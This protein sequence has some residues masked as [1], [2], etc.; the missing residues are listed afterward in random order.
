MKLTRLNSYQLVLKYLNGFGPEGQEEEVEQP[1]SLED[2]FSKLSEDTDL[3]SAPDEDLDEG[4]DPET[5]GD[6]G[7]EQNVDDGKSGNQDD[8]AKP[9]V[10]DAPAEQPAETKPAVE[11][12]T[13]TPA[14]ETPPAQPEPLTAEQEAEQLKQLRGALE[15]S[16]AL[17]DEDADA[18]LTDPKTALPR[19]MANAHLQIMG[20]V[21]QMLQHVVPQILEVTT[22]QSQTKQSIN[23]KFAAR[24]P[25]LAADAANK[26][27]VIAAIQTVKAANPTLSVDEVI[28]KVG[29]VAY[30]IIG[31]PVPVAAPAAQQQ[32]APKVTPP[33]ARPHTPA[34]S[35]VTPPK[36]T[37]TGNHLVDFISSLVDNKE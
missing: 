21:A 18:V 20:Q 16:Y 22:K 9:A 23:D 7:G 33:K 12:P 10:T 25:E 8:P 1:S 14:V 36:Q 35:A 32:P 19:L 5:G 24:W 29:P 17:T 13:P 11:T 30:A 2:F 15:Q 3:D 34:K 37:A 27:S 6:D 4:G 26:Q 28:E 31:K